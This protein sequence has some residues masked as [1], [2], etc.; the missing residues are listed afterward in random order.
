MKKN[1]VYI[2]DTHGVSLL[3]SLLLKSLKKDTTYIHVGDVGLGFVDYNQ[4]IALLTRIN[5]LLILQNNELL[6]LRGNHDNPNFWNLDLKLS[7]V[8]LVKD[9][10][11]LDNHLFIGGAISVDRTLRTINKDYWEN[12]KIIE[13]DVTNLKGI[14]VVVTH[15]K[16]KIQPPYTINNFIKEIS[17]KDKSLL[18]ELDEEQ[19]YLTKVYKDLSVNNDIKL[20][21]NGHF[22][23]SNT[24]Y[25]EKTKFVTLDINEFYEEL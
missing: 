3:F 6:L 20:W 14:E 8:K 17:K 21:I 18:I 22:H 9:Y 13:K 4:D 19:E 11:V 1:I 15:S 5:H 7:N 10:E 12:E 25:F 23:N 2:G 16:T 24:T